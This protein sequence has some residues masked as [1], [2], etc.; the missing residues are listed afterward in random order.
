MGDLF[1]ERDAAVYGFD[2]QDP[3]VADVVEHPGAGCSDISVPSHWTV[4]YF[5]R[6]EL[7]HELRRSPAWRGGRLRR[8]PTAKWKKSKCEDAILL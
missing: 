5:V 4:Y 1:P 7:T 6:D 8:T 2:L 3:A